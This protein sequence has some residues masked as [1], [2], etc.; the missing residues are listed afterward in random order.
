[1]NYIDYMSGGGAAEK[2]GTYTT[3]T[4][5]KTYGPKSSLE[6]V[7]HNFFRALKDLAI[8]IKNLNVKTNPVAPTSSEFNNEHTVST[9][10]HSRKPV[11]TKNFVLTTNSTDALL[12]ST[13][14]NK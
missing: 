4:P 5:I 2:S 10:N 13:L 6:R 1:M 14:D 12:S 11:L 8:Q 3:S 7:D 9:V